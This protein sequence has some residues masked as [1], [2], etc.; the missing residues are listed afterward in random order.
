M[1]AISLWE[2]WASAMALGLK[3]N[4]TRDW[5]ISH[6]GDIVICSAKRKMTR[7]DLETLEILV[8]PSAP[9]FTLTYGC[10]LCVVEVYD[11]VRSELF[12]DAVERRHGVTSLYKGRPLTQ[13]EAALG[14]YSHGRWV[15]LT[16][17][18]RRLTTPVPVTGKQGIFILPPDVEAKV[19]E[20]LGR[21]QSHRLI[22]HVEATEGKTAFVSVLNEDT[23]E[24]FEAEI[25]LA[26]LLNN[27]IGVNDEF[28][29]RFD[30]RCGRT[31]VDL[32]P[33]PPKILSN[34]DIR[35]ISEEVDSQL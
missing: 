17:N 28:L 24:R 10:A 2:P 14:D 7:D 35:R 1:K 33:L 31:I 5:P 20:Q 6:R 8:K 22:G 32:A 18:L 13:A 29:C 23:G 27:R 25:D 34:D 30:A 12:H 3:K 19:R 11:C 26:L 4:E 9:E 16:R 15:W 21:A